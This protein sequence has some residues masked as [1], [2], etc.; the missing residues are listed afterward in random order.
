M[1][2]FYIMEEW[3]SSIAPQEAKHRLCGDKRKEERF[4]KLEMDHLDFQTNR[5]K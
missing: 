2:T 3:S 5:V 1:A 4:F